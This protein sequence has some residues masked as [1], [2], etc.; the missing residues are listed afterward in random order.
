MTIELTNEQAK[1]TYNA[2]HKLKEDRIQYYDEYHPGHSYR[3]F[4][5]YRAICE[6]MSVIY[7]IFKKSNPPQEA[8]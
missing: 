7:E 8:K 5:E 2:L 1:V 3:V 4:A 6:A